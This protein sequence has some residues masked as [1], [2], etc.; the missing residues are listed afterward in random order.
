[1][2]VVSPAIKDTL[3]QAARSYLVYLALQ[4]RTLV[5]IRDAERI[6]H[7]LVIGGGKFG[8]ADL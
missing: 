4:L 5:F 7:K 2:L 8:A 3:L 6:A 1:M